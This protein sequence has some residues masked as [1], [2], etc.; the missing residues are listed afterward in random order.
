MSCLRCLVQVA[1]IMPPDFQ[2]SN[3]FYDLFQRVNKGLFGVMA[4]VD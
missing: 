2:L 1:R 3:F 4:G